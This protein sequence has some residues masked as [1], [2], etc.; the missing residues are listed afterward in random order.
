[1]KIV[2][3]PNRSVVIRGR[4]QLFPGDDLVGPLGEAQAQEHVKSGFAVV[5]PDAPD[6]PSETTTKPPDLSAKKWGM[7]PDGLTG[8]TLEHLNLLVRERD[9]SIEPF[10]TVEEAIAQLS[11][12]F[13]PL[14]PP[15]GLPQ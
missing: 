8:H 13:V 12:E 9:P 14:A 5:V 1:M 6:A 2:V 10:A 11:S 3:A 4:L 15:A 7:D